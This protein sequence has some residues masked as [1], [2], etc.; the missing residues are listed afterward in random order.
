MFHSACDMKQ[1]M[2]FSVKAKENGKMW[3]NG[4]LWGK[5]IQESQEICYPLTINK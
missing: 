4:I 3:N 5:K 1:K 2:D